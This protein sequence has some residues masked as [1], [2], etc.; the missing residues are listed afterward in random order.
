MGREDVHCANLLHH[1][2]LK[3]CEITCFSEIFLLFRGGGGGKEEKE[4]GGRGKERERDRDRDIEIE[5]ETE[6]EIE[7]LRRAVKTA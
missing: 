5:I 3:C 2:H 1:Q 6:T 7:V 4:E